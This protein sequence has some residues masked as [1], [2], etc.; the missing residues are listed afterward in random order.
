MNVLKSLLKRG[1]PRALF[2]KSPRWLVTCVLRRQEL[3]GELATKACYEV[4]AGSADE[5]RDAV[6]AFLRQSQPQ[7]RADLVVVTRQPSQTSG[8]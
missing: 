5:A 3:F 1:N 8:S 7:S 6:L 4:T 2:S